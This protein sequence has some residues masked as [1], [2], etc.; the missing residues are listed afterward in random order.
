MA[1]E[2]KA[3]GYLSEPFDCPVPVAPI[4]EVYL[5]L[6]NPLHDLESVWWVLMWTLLRYTPVSSV[7]TRTLLQAKQHLYAGLF[8]YPFRLRHC[9]FASTA[10]WAPLPADSQ[11]ERLGANLGRYLKR[12]YMAVEKTIPILAD[13]FDLDVFT[14]FIDTLV[15]MRQLFIDAGVDKVVKVWEVEASKLPK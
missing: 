5:F 14:T 13:A 10:L 11:A 7:P 3:S 12:Q 6:H 2:V 4:E 9:V 1:L 15:D 8:N